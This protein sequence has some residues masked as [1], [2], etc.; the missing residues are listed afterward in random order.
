MADKATFVVV[1]A[2]LC[3]AS[4]ARAD[5]KEDC[6]TA[7][8]Q[9]QSLRKSGELVAAREKAVACS[10]AEC[11]YAKK[12]CVQWLA[13]IDASMP[14]VVF[15][16]EDAQGVD[17]TAVRVSVDGKALGDRLDGKAVAVDP[18]EHVI[19]FEMAGFEPI[20]QK[21]LIREGE[22][23]RRIGVSFE[24]AVSPGPPSPITMPSSPSGAAVEPA[25]S[26]EAPSWAWVT[27]G[28]AL[29]S[30]GVGVGL[31]VASV[32]GQS[33]INDYC[34]KNKPGY[35]DAEC[36][37][38]G[39]ANDLKQGLGG[40]F[41]GAGL[42]ALGVALVAIATAPPRTQRASAA[43]SFGASVSFGPAAAGASVR[44]SF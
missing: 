21:A 14:T 19:R 37:D 40:A 28:L 5:A 42:V 41:L 15:T 26:G 39:S 33:E 8:D 38:L 43:L 22:K 25:P 36:Q 24:K 27:G 11:T 35:G 44:G 10:L 34:G 7:Y 31:V 2:L 13:E 17:A 16:A 12:D 29:A 23:N 3:G 32:S 20:E 6:N 30:A 4:T 18:G 1:A 9:T